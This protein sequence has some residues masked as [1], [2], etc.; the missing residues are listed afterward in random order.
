MYLCFRVNWEQRLCNLCEAAFIRLQTIT[1]CR[2][3]YGYQGSQE[4]SVGKCIGK[5]GVEA[6]HIDD[7]QNYFLPPFSEPDFWLGFLLAL[8]V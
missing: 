2:L 4:Y 7:Y 8:C 1:L 5:L 6:N 3:R